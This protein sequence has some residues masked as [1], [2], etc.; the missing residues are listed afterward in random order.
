M[1][2]MDKLLRAGEGK[3]VQ[4]LAGLVPEINELEPEMRGADRRPTSSAKTGEF[5]ERLDHGEP[6]DDL[7]D[8][9]VRG[10]P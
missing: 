7:H 10:H 4:A 5:R 6:L 8:R 2:F 9:G 3:K 1:G